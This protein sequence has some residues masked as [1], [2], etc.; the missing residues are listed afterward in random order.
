MEQGQRLADLIVQFAGEPS[1]AFLFH[2]EQA[3][4]ELLKFVAGLLHL[5][6]ML[7][8]LAF[9][10]LGVPQAE[11]GHQEAQEAAQCEH[12]EQSARG[13][14]AGF[15]EFAFAIH[16]L[17]L[18]GDSQGAQSVVKLAAPRRHLTIEKGHL[19]LV[20]RVEHR[21]GK[22]LQIVSGIRRDFREVA[23]QSAGGWAPSPELRAPV[24]FSWTVL[25]LLKQ[26]RALGRSGVE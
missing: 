20:G 25:Q 14:A 24:S 5:G 9:H 26:G 23:G 3:C 4:G 15:G 7:L 17:L 12:R 21:L 6:K 8:G 22:G 16:Q 10:I 1:P 19:L 13:A 2:L 18:V 11:A